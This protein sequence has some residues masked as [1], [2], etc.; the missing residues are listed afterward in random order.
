MTKEIIVKGSH[1]QANRDL[2]RKFV[3]KGDKGIVSIIE[4]IDS[5]LYLH[6][7]MNDGSYVGPSCD[8]SWELVSANS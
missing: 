8:N 3:K 4:N 7:E 6:I 2:P 5:D 1:V